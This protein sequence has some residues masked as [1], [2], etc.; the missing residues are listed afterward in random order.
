MNMKSLV[1]LC[2]LGMALSGPARSPPKLPKR[3]LLSDILIDGALA[4]GCALDLKRDFHI[5]K[6]R[7][8]MKGRNTDALDPQVVGWLSDLGLCNKKRGLSD[9]WDSVGDSVGDAVDAGVDSVTE[10]LCGM[11]SKRSAHG[12]LEFSNENIPAMKRMLE[13]RGNNV[14]EH[15]LE[16]FARGWLSDEGICKETRSPPSSKS[17]PA[18]SKRSPPSPKR[19]PP[20]AKRRPSNSPPLPKRGL[21]DLV[22][23]A[24]CAL[25]LK[26][27]FH[28]FKKDAEM[29]GNNIEEAQANVI[30]WLDDMGLCKR[31]RGL[32]DWWDSVGDLTVGDAVDAGVDSVTE[33]L[34]GILS[35][36]SLNEHVELRGW[37]SD[38]GIC[39]D[40]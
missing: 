29:S 1:F 13:I 16:S 9:W 11:L 36:R 17:S 2:L 26:R 19:S 4:A 39:P 38:K 3:F 23:G 37:L 27:D 20:S 15:K 5:F 10:W 6:A 12:D 8:E 7:A 21:L 33:W 25:D 32:S 31:K 30:G 34:C 18:S 35:K 22:L 28:I 14:D 24:G 40:E